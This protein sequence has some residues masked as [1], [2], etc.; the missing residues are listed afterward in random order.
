MFH[1]LSASASVSLLPIVALTQINKEKEIEDYSKT[2]VDLEALVAS[3]ETTTEEI[4]RSVII[5]LVEVETI[6]EEARPELLQ[7]LFIV[8]L[9]GSVL[10]NL[11]FLDR[12]FRAWARYRARVSRGEDVVPPDCT[13]LDAELS[14]LKPAIAPEMENMVSE[15]ESSMMV[16]KEGNEASR[17]NS[18]S[19]EEEESDD[20]RIVTRDI[21]RLPRYLSVRPNGI[22]VG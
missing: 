22:E 2:S 21:E 18:V 5:T 4:S 6:G 16:G 9:V 17:T 8:G 15:D 3:E 14:L 11:P 19:E 1:F 20:G 12:V 7:I 10:I 13:V